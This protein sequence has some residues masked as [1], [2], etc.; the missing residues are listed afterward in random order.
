M[1]K[2]ETDT[3]QYDRIILCEEFAAKI[4]QGYDDLWQNF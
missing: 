3:K 2:K 4:S 1:Q